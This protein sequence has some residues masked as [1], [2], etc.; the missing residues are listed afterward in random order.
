MDINY[1]KPCGT[2]N[3]KHLISLENYTEEEILGAINL[4][5]TENLSEEE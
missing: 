5:A 2:L 3:K 1:Y 4:F